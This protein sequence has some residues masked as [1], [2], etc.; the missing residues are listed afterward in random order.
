[1]TGSE[2]PCITIA[3]GSCGRAAGADDTVNAFLEELERLGIDNVKVRKVGCVGF[4][5]MEPLVAVRMPGQDEVVYGR[6]DAD[7]ARMI[8]SRHILNGQILAHHTLEGVA[9]TG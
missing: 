3:A 5:E 6:V 4:C 8:V 1:M 2:Y 9:F 7:A